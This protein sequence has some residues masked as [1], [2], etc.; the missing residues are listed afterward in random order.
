MASSAPVVSKV[1]NNDGPNWAGA[2]K[3]S[4]GHSSLCKAHLW[5]SAYWVKALLDGAIMWGAQGHDAGRTEDML[6]AASAHDR[7]CC[8]GAAHRERHACD[9]WR[10]G[11][12]R[13]WRIGVSLLRAQQWP[14]HTPQ[15]AQSGKKVENRWPAKGMDEGPTDQQ[16]HRAPQIQ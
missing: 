1:G 4:P 7:D 2:Q 16:P 14:S 8:P 13:R 5:L 9:R 15:Q 6:S 12:W 3:Y 10:R 11:G